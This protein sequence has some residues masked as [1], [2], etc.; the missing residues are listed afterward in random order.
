MVWSDWSV[1]SFLLL[2]DW[3]IWVLV[4]ELMQTEFHHV[5]T[6][7]VMT[8]VLRRGLLEEVQ[9]EHDVIGQIFPCLDDLLTLHRNFL[10]ELENRH[11]TAT[12]LSTNKNFIIHRIGDILL[13]QV[14]IIFMRVH[15]VLMCVHPVFVCVHACVCA[16]VTCVNVCVCVQFSGPSAGH[17]M[18]L[19]GNFCSKQSEALKIYK[20]L[21][22]SNRKLQL[23]L[24]VSLC[25]SN[26]HTSIN[27]FS[28]VSIMLKT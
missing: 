12:H 19:Y 7:T 9:L 28:L 26:T 14:C 17:M 1:K 6:L 23:F 18:A 13:Q 10:T 11:H 5:Q 22:Q 24:R 2:P 4:S 16:C 15:T 25:N 3:L 27:I 20:Q 8:D 21:Q